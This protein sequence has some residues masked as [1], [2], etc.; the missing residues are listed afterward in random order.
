MEYQIQEVKKKLMKCRALLRYGNASVWDRI[1]S[2][3]T[4]L[5]TVTNNSSGTLNNNKILRAIEQEECN[6]ILIDNYMHIVNQLNQDART[7][8]NLAYMTNHYSVEKIS[9]TLHMSVRNVQ[10]ILSDSLRV[11][12]YLDSDI[13]YTINDLYEYYHS[14]SKTC[15][16]IKKTV[17]S[18]IKNNESFIKKL[19]T[20]ELISIEELY[21]YY[22][23]DI[24]D[25]YKKRKILRT[26]YL[27]ALT[28]EIIN[29]K[30]YIELMNHT[31]ERITNIEKK[32][33]KARLFQKKLN[34]K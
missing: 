19:L 9:E 20:D 17:E 2:Y 30:D 27:I 23:K 6:K 18:L 15:L 16:V 33:K 11:I 1:S 24:T 32:I 13:D 14:K 12:A 7:I 4:S 21:A 3:S 31:Q 29:E 34:L 26:I 10:R 22:S 25:K 28:F 8:I 5:I